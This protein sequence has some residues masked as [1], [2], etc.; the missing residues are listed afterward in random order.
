MMAIILSSC[1][2]F[3]GKNEP[4][5]SSYE[6]YFKQEL[7]YDKYDSVDALNTA[8][9]DTSYFWKIVEDGTCI[10]YFSGKNVLF[11][12]YKN[13]PAIYVYFTD[14]NDEVLEANSFYKY[15]PNYDLTD[16]AQKSAFFN[17]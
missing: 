3:G 10:S 5:Y 8:I 9:G 6:D 4:T 16:P 17:T 11:S 1:G 15:V 2:I 13:N 7:K 12:V 14:G